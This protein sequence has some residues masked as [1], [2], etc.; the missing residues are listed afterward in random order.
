[1]LNLPHTDEMAT[2]GFVDRNNTIELRTNQSILP[3]RYMFNGYLT[4]SDN[5]NH[6]E[7]YEPA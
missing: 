7:M 3:Y 1:M 4:C 2:S 6:C 5:K